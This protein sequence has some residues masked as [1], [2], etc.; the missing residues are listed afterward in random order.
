MP[1][2]SSLSDKNLEKLPE[3]GGP[4]HAIKDA[5]A[6]L[7]RNLKRVFASIAKPAVEVKP[8]R[9]GE[10]AGDRSPH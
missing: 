6:A 8:M 4:L 2:F 9:N 5:A 3:E 7:R 10:V 1:H